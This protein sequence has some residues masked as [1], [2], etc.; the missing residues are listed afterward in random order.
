[1]KNGVYSKMGYEIAVGGVHCLV[2]Y[3]NAGIFGMKLYRYKKLIAVCEH[4]G[5]KKKTLYAFANNRNENVFNDNQLC[6]VLGGDLA[7]IDDRDLFQKED[8]QIVSAD[9]EMPTVSKKGIAYCLKH[10][11]LGNRLDVS[12][13]AM[14]FTMNTNKIE[15]VMML[16]NPNEDIYCGASVTIPYDNGLFGGRQ[17]FRI[18][19]YADNSKPWCQFHCFLGNDA[20]LPDFQIPECPTGSCI[21]TNEGLLFEVK[22][23]TDDEIVLQGCGDD[24]YFYRRDA[25]MSERF[26][27]VS[28]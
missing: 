23:Y 3:K 26:S 28:T 12:E 5:K 17:Y 10:W 4:D 25:Q 13:D 20:V 18:R 14:N 21:A 2:L 19:N 9:T 15:Y 22:R 27:A 8:I 24:E 16:R 11:K 1:M 6:S 7:V